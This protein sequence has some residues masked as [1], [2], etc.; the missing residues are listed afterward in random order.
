[1]DIA[2]LHHP[3]QGKIWKKSIPCY[4]TIYYSTAYTTGY[5]FLCYKYTSKISEINLMFLHLTNQAFVQKYIIIYYFTLNV[6]Y[7]HKYK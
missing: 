5:V 3:P 4:H 7:Y 2:E 6:S 1:M